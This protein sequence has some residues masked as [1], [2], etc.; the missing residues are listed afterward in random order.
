MVESVMPFND[1]DFL[2][3]VTQWPVFLLDIP[4]CCLKKPVEGGYEYG[5]LMHGSPKLYHGVFFENGNGETTNFESFE[6]IVQE[7]WLVD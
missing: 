1:L 5:F 6:A 7:G 3:D 4:Y 2:K